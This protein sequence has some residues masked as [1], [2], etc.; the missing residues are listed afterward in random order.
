MKR[1]LRLALL[2]AL[3]PA[4]LLATAAR[5]SVEEFSTFHVAVIES[6]DENF[7]DHWLVRTP[8]RWQDEYRAAPNAFRT[9]QGCYT[10]G[11]WYQEN[12]FKARATLGKTAFLDIGF[13]QL[14][15]DMSQYEWIRFEF[16]FRTG[17]AGTFGLRFQPAPD[18]SRQDFA[19]LWDWGEPGGPVEINAAFTVEDA[20]NSLWEFRQA[21]VGDHSEPYRAHPVEPALRVVTRGRHHRVELAGKW[22]TPLRAEL[23][24]PGLVVTGDR[25][26]WGAHGALVAEAFLGPWELEARAEN[27]QALSHETTLGTPGDGHNFRRLWRV[28]GAVRRQV[29]ADW[30]VEARG[31]YQDRDE[32]W[33]P[34]LGDGAFF[35]LDRGLAAEV[36]GEPRKNWQVRAGVMHD[37]VGIEEQGWVPVGTY[38]T[39]KES[40]AYLGLELL[41]GRVRVAGIEGIELDAEPYDVTFHHDKGYLQLQTTF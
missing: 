31:A 25:S 12:D 30:R 17:G 26:L 32:T 38:G 16:R 3:L 4:L 41:F 36:A 34:P 10:A 13:R 28:E 27:Q 5:A 8:V 7:F 15:D 20:F 14:F 35:A 39:R 23:Q 37:R 21:Q 19:A 6:D 29:A 18:K 22:L 40:R 33:R 24:D 9:S 11:Q 2:P 1:R